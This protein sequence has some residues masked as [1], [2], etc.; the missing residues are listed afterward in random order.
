MQWPITMHVWLVLTCPAQAPTY[1]HS[2]NVDV[3]ALQT[4][5]GALLSIAG[6]CQELQFDLHIMGH[7]ASSILLKLTC[8]DCTMYPK[9]LVHSIDVPLMPVCDEW[10]CVVLVLLYVNMYV[11]TP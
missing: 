6:I 7:G 11:Y 5:G 8:A 9:L 4:F 10:L 2:P 3:T 1:Q